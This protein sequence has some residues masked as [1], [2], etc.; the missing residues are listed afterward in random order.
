MGYNIGAIISIGGDKEYQRALQG[1]RSAMTYVKAEA[2]AV[3][4]AFDKNDKSIGALTTKNKALGAALD[5]QKKAVDEAKAALSRLDAQ[6]IDPSSEAYQKMTANLN[7]A[8]AEFNRTSNEIKS[9]EH[10]MAQLNEQAKTEKLQKFKDALKGIGEIAGKAVVVGLKT[11]AAAMAAIGTAAVAAG[12]ALWKNGTNAGEFADDLLTLSAQTGLTVQELQEL[13]Y[14]SRFVDV[15]VTSLAKGMSKTVSAMRESATAGR[16][17][18]EAA[19]GIKIAMKGANGETKSTRAVFYEAIDALGAITDETMREVAAQDLFGKSYQDLMPL[20]KAGSGALNKYAEE[21]RA[22]GLILSNE[23][24][25]KLGEFDD[26]MQRTEAQTEGIGRQLAVTFL[27]GLQK[28][29]TGI[30]EFL[31]IVTNALQNGIQPG[32]VKTIGTWI[33]EKLVEGLKTIKQ[34][35]PEV[36]SLIS[37]L[38]TEVVGVVVAALP[39]ILP[40][41]MDGAFQLI[42][43]LVTAITENVEPLAVMIT[44]MAT[45]LVLF[46]LENLPM[47]I[48]AAAQILAAITLGISQNLPTLIPAVVSTVMEIAN[49]LISN[50]GILIPAA[51][52]II[53]AL[54]QGLTAALP[55]L[56]SYLPTI[57]LTI[58]TTLINNLPLLLDAAWQIILA[59]G[60]GLVAALPEL[61]KAVPQIIVAIVGA[62]GKLVSQLWEAGKNIVKGLW[63]GIQKAYGWL[64]D[65]VTGFFKGIIKSVTSFL[66][67][68]SPSTVFAGI[69]ENMALGLG[70]GFSAAMQEVGRTIQKSIPSTSA[71]VTVTGGKNGLSAAAA[72]VVPNLTISTHDSLSPYEILQE[73]M[74]FQRR[75]A[76]QS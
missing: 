12:T 18:I 62:L 38:L 4:S 41:L 28:V 48:A 50:V 17:Y 34:Y 24:V 63:E 68:H 37:G 19:G 20:I 73:Y 40:V 47:L 29:G 2:N 30:S 10:A 6:G 8:Q 23:M 44:T 22:A 74:N 61:V 52:Q 7:N 5:L 51:L 33:S 76:W 54:I 60:Q 75:V 53:V 49:A 71:D 39:E 56:I 26:V 32:D 11:T 69:G 67:I 46:I 9:N 70:K 16:D 3:T 72:G 42:Q 64:K 57:V 59:L 65:K 25:A 36:I 1:I 35:L 27:P 43:G 55:Q 66:G 58:T 13:Q 15:E 21:A 45:Q 14:A 31:S